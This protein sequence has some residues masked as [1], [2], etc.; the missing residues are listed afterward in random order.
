ME[1]ALSLV[2]KVSRYILIRPSYLFGG[3][4]L[5]TGLAKNAKSAVIPAGPFHL[6]LMFG[7]LIFESGAAEG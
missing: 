2:D 6:A 3:I 7:P 1:D 4:S 5:L